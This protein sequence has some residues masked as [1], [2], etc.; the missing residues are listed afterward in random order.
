MIQVVMDA[1]LFTLRLRT[2]PIRSFTTTENNL[3]ACNKFHRTANVLIQEQRWELRKNMADTLCQQ[4]KL[5]DANLQLYEA[6]Q[7][8]TFLEIEHAKLKKL[9]KPKFWCAC[10]NTFRPG[11]SY[12]CDVEKWLETHPVQQALDTLDENT[13]PLNDS[14]SQFEKDVYEIKQKLAR[15]ESVMRHFLK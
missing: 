11:E 7:F 6:N 1:A 12:K 8:R 3:W 13:I 5:E 14:Y 2:H 10:G 9:P 15:I 4:R